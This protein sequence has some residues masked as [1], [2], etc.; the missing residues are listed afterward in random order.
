MTN[1]LARCRCS[2]A[3]CRSIG[4]TRERIQISRTKRQRILQQ[5]CDL[6]PC[7][8]ELGIHQRS[9]ITSTVTLC[10]LKLFCLRT[11]S[12]SPRTRH[13]TRKHVLAITGKS[14]SS[15]LNAFELR[16]FR[17]RYILTAVVNTG[18]QA[19]LRATDGKPD[20]DH[21]QQR[22]VVLYQKCDYN[23]SLFQVIGYEPCAATCRY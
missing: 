22:L 23:C 8:L 16:G 19:F 5:Q 13:P 3:G 2:S 15:S 18:Q 12:A 4:D 10:P 7:V 21:S 20:H 1:P 17:H 11:P 9:K 6:S 14:T